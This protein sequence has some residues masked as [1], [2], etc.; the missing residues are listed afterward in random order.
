MQLLAFRARLPRD[1]VRVALLAG[2]ALAVVPAALPPTSIRVRT[3]AV[4]V[5]TTATG[6]GTST[7]HGTRT[8]I[9]VSPV[10][11]SWTAAV[12]RRGPAMTTTGTSRVPT[13]GT[14]AA[15]VSLTAAGL[16]MTASTTAPTTLRLPATPVAHIG[17]MAPTLPLGAAPVAPVAPG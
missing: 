1:S 6:V 11:C 2:L 12:R 9:Y 13:L 14:T 4:G 17:L 7:I 3:T 10:V 15:F 5:T 8:P 16:S